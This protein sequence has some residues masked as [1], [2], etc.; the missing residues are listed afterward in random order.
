MQ[1][2]GQPRTQTARIL[3]D[4]LAGGTLGR[5]NACSL[6]A[7]SGGDLAAL[8]QAASE[9]R[10]LYK[11][12]IVTYSRKVFIPLTNLCRDVCSYCTF[13]RQPDDPAARTMT[14]EDVLDAARQGQAAGCKEALF[15]LGDKPE[16]KYP[17]YRDWL[18]ARGYASTI[19]YLSEMCEL[20][21]RETGL[22][23]HANPGILT[24]ADIEALRPYNA[25]MGLML[26]NVSTRLLGAG[27]PHHRCPD[28]APQLRLR[29][30]EEAGRQRVAFTTGILIGIG[31]TLEERVDS[32]LAIR[33][34]HQ[35]Y[36]HVQEVI[37]QNFRAKP[38]IPMRDHPDATALDMARTIAVARLLLGDM[39]I[40]APPNLTPEAYGF[41]L[42]AGINDWGGISPV[43][44]DFINPEAPWPQ[45]EELRRVCEEAGFQLRERLAL[46]PEYVRAGDGFIP[47]ALR[48]RISDL[49]DADGL[50]RRELEAA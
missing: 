48:R 45:V 36:G 3:D 20:V 46:Y 22:L 10:D 41:Y 15:S 24:A 44:R 40:Q 26:E 27:M 42:L 8:L 38:D 49:T 39:N 14:S 16:L 34:L 23:P 7:S 32:L 2:V 29:T 11:G 13:V 37:I 30:I 4:A 25:S 31:E 50:V 9:L 21:A 5:D 12:R 28:K 43:T 47:D 35:R 19:E 6:L 17:E 1:T 33:D 18:G